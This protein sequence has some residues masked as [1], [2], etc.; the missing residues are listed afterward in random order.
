MGFFVDNPLANRTGFFGFSLS[1]SGAGFGSG[2]GMSFG[3]F[4][5]GPGSCLLPDVRF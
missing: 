1:T 5:A 2:A 3:F 4:G